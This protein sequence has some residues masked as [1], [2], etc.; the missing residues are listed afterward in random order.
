LDRAAGRSHLA[1]NLM[2]GIDARPVL[3]VML[4]IL[5][6]IGVGW[7]LMAGF[8]AWVLYRFWSLLT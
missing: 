1:S 5:A 7:L 8:T 3:K 6:I 2:F 4:P